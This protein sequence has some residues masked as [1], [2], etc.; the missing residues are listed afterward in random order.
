MFNRCAF[1]FGLLLALNSTSVVAKGTLA[2]CTAWCG[3]HCAGMTKTGGAAE[4]CKSKCE[5]R[6]GCAQKPM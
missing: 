1:I 6:R 5:L 4:N 3:R 2:D